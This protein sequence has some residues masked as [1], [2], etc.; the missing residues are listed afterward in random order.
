MGSWKEM[1]EEAT[2]NFCSEFVVEDDYTADSCFNRMIAEHL[3]PDIDAEDPRVIAIVRKIKENLSQRNKISETK[4]EVAVR[5]PTAIERAM[6]N[7][8]Y[9][10]ILPNGGSPD[11]INYMVKDFRMRRPVKKLNPRKKRRRK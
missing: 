2:D 3:P 8:K 4:E 9:P 1:L 11:N 7:D 6:A 5:K 10:Y